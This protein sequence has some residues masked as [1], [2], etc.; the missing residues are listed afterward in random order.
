MQFR[1]EKMMTSLFYLLYTEETPQGW[2]QTTETNGPVVIYDLQAQPLPEILCSMITRLIPH[3][4]QVAEST[5]QKMQKHNMRFEL[6]SFNELDGFGT[7]ASIPSLD[8]LDVQDIFD[9]HQNDDFRDDAL[10]LLNV[11][12]IV[13]LWRRNRFGYGQGHFPQTL[14]KYGERILN[15]SSPNGE[16]WE[17]DNMFFDF[18][19][20]L[21][22][23]PFSLKRE[24]K[25]PMEMVLDDGEDIDHDGRLDVAD[26]IDPEACDGLLGLPLHQCV[27]DNLMTFYD[28]QANRLILRPL[29]FNATTMYTCVLDESHQR[30]KWRKHTI[31]ISI[32]PHDKHP[33]CNKQKHLSRYNLTLGYRFRL[34]FYNR[35]YDKGFGRT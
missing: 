27:A 19:I 12:P 21:I 4:Q 35:F 9:R 3:L 17:I 7:Y 13:P 2:V 25:I 34:E 26:F 11:D 20:V 22:I 23:I 1:G 6:K 30:R 18:T 32:N 5:S 14:Y 28:R 10:Y 24:T 16:H 33:M 31:P 15:E 8:A 29:C